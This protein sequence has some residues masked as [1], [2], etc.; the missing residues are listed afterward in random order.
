[1]KGLE[2]RVDNCRMNALMP[3]YRDWFAG[4]RFAPRR[5][6]VEEAGVWVADNY[7]PV[8]VYVD[9][10][11]GCPAEPISAQPTLG[12]PFET[13]GL[14][15]DADHLY[16]LGQRGLYALDR[17]TGSPVWHQPDASSEL[18]VSEG[19]IW[20]TIGADVA[21]IDRCGGVA[22]RYCLPGC[23]LRSC[24]PQNGW[25]AVGATLR[26]QIMPL[27]VARFEADAS[28]PTWITDL[29]GSSGGGWRRVY[30]TQ[31]TIWVI[32]QT[33][34]QEG[35]MRRHLCSLDATTGK[36]I[37]ELPLDP[38]GRILIHDGLAWAWSQLSDKDGRP[39]RRAV[40]LFDPLT[41]E[42]RATH[43]LGTRAA[44]WPAAGPRGV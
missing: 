7:L 13:W 19:R 14:A 23:N 18:V 27:R 32:R 38:S 12:T 41:G 42:I 28:T 33:P 39:L 43:D 37:R 36:V 31:D 3:H 10:A 35:Q 24:A 20:T 9:L 17:E 6:T 26:R 25:L 29:E 11:S 40:T 8:F 5:V 30:A 22:H 4:Y 2:L 34:P 1:M 21:E 44:P 15:S 16:V